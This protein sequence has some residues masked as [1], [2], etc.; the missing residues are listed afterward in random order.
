M[1]TRLRKD[2]KNDFEKDF[3]KL[4]NNAV[5]GKTMG[6]IK[7]HRNIELLISDKRRSLLVSEQ[8]YYTSK[9]IS[10]DLMIIEM[11]K[12]WVKMNKPIYLGQAILDISKTLMHEFWYD[13]IL[14]MRI[15]RDYVICILI[16]L[17]LILKLKIFIKVLLML[18]KNGLIL[19]NM[20][21]VMGDYCL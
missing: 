4:M 6:N 15:K 3:P 8:N 1:N 5:F 21:K 16:A 18:L 13:Y 14:N 10:E 12:L 19:L 9:H 20:I 17:L 2:A 7:K 11:K